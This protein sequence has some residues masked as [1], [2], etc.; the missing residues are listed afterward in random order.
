MAWRRIGDKPLPEMIIAWFT[1][2]YKHYFASMSLLYPSVLKL[3][4]VGSDNGL[5]PG[6]HQAINWTN[7][8]I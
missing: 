7:A 2:A 3:T 6:R 1:D 4:I 8:G 5:L